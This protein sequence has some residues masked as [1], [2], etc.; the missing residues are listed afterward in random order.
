MSD[1]AT[2]YGRQAALKDARKQEL[3]PANFHVPQPTHPQQYTSAI[4]GNHAERLAEARNS[5]NGR[6]DNIKNTLNTAKNIAET[7]SPTGA[8]SLLRQVDFIGDM[9]YAAALG[10]ALVKDL[11]D[12]VV[13]ETVILSILFSMLCS[14]F[15]FMMMLLV[16]SN[17]KKKGATS[18][19]KK[20]GVLGVG[21]IADSIPGI[22]FFPIETLTVAI[23]YFLTLVERKNS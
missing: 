15:I 1:I 4:G 9:P 18:L 6:M 23:I 13:A 2:E 20:I 17:G 12:F 10:A 21:G 19:L 5:G 16:G 11:L 7:A 3:S 22:D 14:I 8:L